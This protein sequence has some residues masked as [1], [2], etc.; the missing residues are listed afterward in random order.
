MRF[1]CCYDMVLLNTWIIIFSFLLNINLI[2]WD[3]FICNFKYIF[4]NETSFIK[5]K[6]VIV[7][8]KLTR[9]R[10]LWSG[11]ELR[12]ALRGKDGARQNHMGRR[13]RPHPLTLPYPI[14]IPNCRCQMICLSPMKSLISHSLSVNNGLNF[15]P[16][17]WI[18][19]STS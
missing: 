13:K 9:S 10:V 2:W 14:V 7:A 3:K 17:N 1:F 5:K 4:I 15:H 8:G 19:S 16:L 6:I 12:G 11:A 18:S